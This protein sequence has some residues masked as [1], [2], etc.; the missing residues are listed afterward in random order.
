MS[1]PSG[2]QTSP[3]STRLG[4]YVAC[5]FQFS[6]HS[7]NSRLALFPVAGVPPTDR[8]ELACVLPVPVFFLDQSIK[9]NAQ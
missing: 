8:T 5:C 2:L 6:Q 9:V 7:P 3:P 1:V 4:G